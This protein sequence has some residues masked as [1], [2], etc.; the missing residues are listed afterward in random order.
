MESAEAQNVGSPRASERPR[1]GREE[2]EE[3]DGRRRRS[4]CSATSPGL[5]RDLIL[6]RQGTQHKTC[7]A[8]SGHSLSLLLGGVPVNPRC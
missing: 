1:E 6:G 7:N 3:D 8:L 4:G 5:T 2:Q